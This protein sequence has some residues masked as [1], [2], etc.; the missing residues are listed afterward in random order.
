MLLVIISTKLVESRVEAL[1]S[2]FKVY[3]R[4]LSWSI[5]DI[6]GIPQEIYIYKIKLE[7]IAYQV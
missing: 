3:R 6:V 1:L 2:V 7:E 5:A 4:A